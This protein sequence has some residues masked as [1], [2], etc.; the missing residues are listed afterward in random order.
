MSTKD[1]DILFTERLLEGARRGEMDEV[2][3]CLDNGIDI[4]SKDEV[5]FN[6]SFNFDT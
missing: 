1:V 6:D 3:R 2:T 5:R 4:E